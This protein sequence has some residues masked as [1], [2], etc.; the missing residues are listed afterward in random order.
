MPS[1]IQVPSRPRAPRSIAYGAHV[2]Q[3]RVASP[4]SHQS[5]LQAVSHVII[6]GMR[7]SHRTAYST[8][9][10]IMR[11][12]WCVIHIPSN[13]IRKTRPASRIASARA[14]QTLSALSAL[15]DTVAE[16]T[17]LHKIC[18]TAGCDAVGSGGG[19][20]SGA[21]RA[22]AASF[23]AAGIGSITLARERPRTVR[24][25]YIRVWRAQAQP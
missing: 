21:L 24:Q 2:S 19:E 12:P 22:E 16:H 13:N 9:I 18:C 4:A 11:Y 10:T 17:R 6:S 1:T 23:A 20:R 14:M 8:P 15:V 25:A 5:S 7:T 3:A